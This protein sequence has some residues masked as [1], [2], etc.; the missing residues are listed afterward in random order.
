MSD[1]FIDL[2]M[3]NSRL[4]ICC[5]PFS[6]ESAISADSLELSHIQLVFRKACQCIDG[7]TDSKVLICYYHHSCHRSGRTSLLIVTDQIQGVCRSIYTRQSI[8][9]HVISF[10]DRFIGSMLYT[11]NIHVTDD[12]TYICR[13]CIYQHKINRDP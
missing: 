8:C 12:F 6:P 13:H 11:G 10:L 5:S 9:S 3:L 7:F 1:E 4:F 2:S